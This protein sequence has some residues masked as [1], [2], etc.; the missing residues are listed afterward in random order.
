MSIKH[1]S[2]RQYR[3]NR[4]RDML[5]LDLFCGSGGLTVGL[6]QAGFHVIGAV[7]NDA[8]AAETYRANHRDVRLWRGDIR[9]LNAE[10]VMRELHLKRG[11]LT[12]LAGCPPCQGFSTMRTL[13]GARKV[14]DARNDLVFEFC[15]FVAALRPQAVLMENV[16]GLADDRRMATL[17]RRLR[18][19]GYRYISVSVRNAADFGVPQRRRRTILVAT[20]YGAVDLDSIP[21]EHR[22]VR[23][24]IA[25][26]PP[27]GNTGDPLHDILETR[28]A[29]TLAL[30]T[31]IPKDGGSRSALGDDQLACHKKCSGFRDVYGRMCWDDVAPTITSGCTNPSKGRF[32]H[33][34][35]DRAITLREAALLQTFPPTYHFSLRKGKQGAA[36][37]IGN[38]FPPEFIRRIAVVVRESLTRRETGS[39]GGA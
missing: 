25:H 7:D 1:R 11:E 37:L 18:R 2:K 15:R 5:A 19:L 3:R 30:I 8:L 34:W 27:P 22:T 29:E 26:L 24:A 31:K 12:L 35:H 6:S 39:G 21:A 28:R 16:P 13:N 20:R 17:I 14:T 10:R 33:P 4:S 9:R 36:L 38:A 32:L 23:E